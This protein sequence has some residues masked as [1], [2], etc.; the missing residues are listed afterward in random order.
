MMKTANSRKMTSFVDRPRITVLCVAVAWVLL[1][2]IA[3]AG[4]A[5]GSHQHRVPLPPVRGR[6]LRP[7]PQIKSGVLTGRFVAMVG[8]ARI[9]AFSPNTETYVFEA[10]FR[11]YTQLVKIT[12]E[13]LHQEPRLPPGVLDY[14]QVRSFVAERDSSC[15]E[16][17]RN[18]STRLLFS[19]D[20]E[21]VA[22]RS[23]LQ[24]AEAAPKP[25]IGDEEVLPCY[26]VGRVT[27]KFASRLRGPGPSP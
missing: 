8:G 25:R 14:D 19:S 22:R 21:F 2:V 5:T 9:S 4:Q 27:P 15:D 12:H 23:T 13:F 10:D 17:W 7:L 1:C 16:I 24:L 26:V 3:A 6:R 18:L 20:G 11:G